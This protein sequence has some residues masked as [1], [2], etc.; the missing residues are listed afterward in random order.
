MLSSSEVAQHTSA[1]AALVQ[2]KDWAEGTPWTAAAGNLA[3]SWHSKSQSPQ[4]D[5][6]KG[7]GQ[8]SERHPR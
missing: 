5:S 2:G 1:A 6:P 3:H 8:E 4:Q 7:L